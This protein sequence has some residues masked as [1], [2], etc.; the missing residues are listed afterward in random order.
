MVAIHLVR[1]LSAAILLFPANKY[2][3][4]FA[5]FWRRQ[6]NST[7]LRRITML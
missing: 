4:T 6:W 5:L 1:L 2:Q 7:E 3:K